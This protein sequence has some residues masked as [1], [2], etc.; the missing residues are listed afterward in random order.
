MNFK[1]TGNNDIPQNR[2]LFVKEQN[3]KIDD[4]DRL[5]DKCMEM[6]LR[7]PGTNITI[8]M[9]LFRKFTDILLDQKR[10]LVHEIGEKLEYD[11]LMVENSEL[12]QKITH[13]EINNII[14][15]EYQDDDDEEILEKE[16]D[17]DD[18]EEFTNQSKNVDQYFSNSELSPFNEDQNNGMCQANLDNAFTLNGNW[19]SCNF[20]FGRDDF[21]LLSD[22]KSNSVDFPL[23]TKETI[24][25]DLDANYLKL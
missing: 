2:R 1:Y 9:T 8:P 21:G 4:I 11:S 12:K 15:E 7:S 14:D 22:K 18:I 24:D 5:Y 25:N 6:R 10:S 3:K 17:I 16:I 20:K 13:N 23:G 19:K